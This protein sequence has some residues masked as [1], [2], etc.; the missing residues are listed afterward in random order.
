MSRSHTSSRASQTRHV[1]ASSFDEFSRLS[2]SVVIGQSGI[3][4]RVGFTP[5][6]LET[7][8]EQFSTECRKTKTHVITQ[9]NH[10]GCRIQ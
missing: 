10:K 2:M 4:G 3:L 5:F 9:A 1:F 7:I 6:Q 8:L